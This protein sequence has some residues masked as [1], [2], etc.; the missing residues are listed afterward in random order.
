MRHVLALVLLAL[1]TSAWALHGPGPFREAGRFG[2]GFGA[3]TSTAGLS[4]KYMISPDLSV[5]G[6]VG[7][8]YGAH[9][10]DPGPGGSWDSSLALS[11]DLL[12]EMPT[13]YTDEGLDLAWSIGPGVGTWLSDGYFAL[14]ASGAAGFEVNITAV[15]MD[16]VVE[17]RPRVLLVPDVAV[18]FFNL[19]GHIRYFF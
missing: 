17:Y 13:F 11:A 19:S 6:V 18:D 2:L 3:G 16:V 14:A 7:A 8:G 4:G 9:S 15:P 5:Q 10:T 12:F 1:P